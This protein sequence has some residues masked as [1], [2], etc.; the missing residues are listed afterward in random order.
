MLFKNGVYTSLNIAR[1]ITSRR[2]RRTRHMEHMEM[3]TNAYKLFE[4]NPERKSPRFSHSVPYV[5]F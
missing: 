3:N 1:V 4:G 5:S 2:M